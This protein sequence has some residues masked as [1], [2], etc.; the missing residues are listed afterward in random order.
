MECTV[1]SVCSVRSARVASSCLLIYIPYCRPTCKRISGC[2][3]YTRLRMYHAQ[4]EAWTQTD[5]RTNRCRKKMVYGQTGASALSNTRALTPAGETYIYVY[6][7]IYAGRR[8]IPL[9]GHSIYG[10]MEQSSGHNRGG[11]TVR[12]IHGYTIARYVSI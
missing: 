5:L 4:P 2:S 12:P 9:S 1:C 8:D 11:T 3:L 6:I 7:Y 10:K